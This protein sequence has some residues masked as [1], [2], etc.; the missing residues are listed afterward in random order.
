MKS[1]EIINFLLGSKEMIVTLSCCLET[2][3][4]HSETSQLAVTGHRSK[5]CYMSG[6]H[7]K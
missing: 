5:S 4:G 2:Y 6:K 7:L 1:H 3:K